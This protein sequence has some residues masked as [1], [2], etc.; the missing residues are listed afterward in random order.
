MNSTADRSERGGK[1]DNRAAEE[2]QLTACFVGTQQDKT[3][4]SLA[5][6]ACAAKLQ[7]PA[8]ATGK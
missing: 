8:A 7:D 5:H 4:C 6:G 2:V 3:F 1:P